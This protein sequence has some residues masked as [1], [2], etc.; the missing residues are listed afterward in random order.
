[1]HHQIP[2]PRWVRPVAVFALVFGLLTLKSGGGVLFFEG[3]R[4]AAGDYVPFVVWFNF[5]AG[6][7]YIAAA[8]GLWQWRRWAALLAALLALMTLAV[9]A[10]F[11]LHV[12][13]GGAYEMRTVGAMTLRGGVWVA[14]AAGACRALGCRPGRSAA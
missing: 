10:A 5:L 4:L 3:P 6:F 12:L 11:A 14:I 13:A 7:G 2:R 1:M 9:F 8:V